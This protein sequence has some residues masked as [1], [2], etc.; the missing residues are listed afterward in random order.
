[1]SHMRCHICGD[2]SEAFA[3]TLVLS[4]HQVSYFR[5]KGCRFIQTEP[6]YWLE[7]AYSEAISELDVGVMQRNLH[8][9]GVT[10]AVIS[11]LFPSGVR[12]LDYAAGYGTLVRL[13]RD[14]GFDFFW[15][16]RYAKNLYA[17]GFEHV[18]GSRYDLLTA[19]EVL[20]HLPHPL[21][22]IARMFELAENILVSTILVPEPAPTPP[23]WWYYAVKSGQHISLYTADSL[24]K[25][26]SRFHVHLLSRGPYHLLTH[27][28]QSS[29]RFRVATS[30]R[31][32]PVVNF[33]CRRPSL[34]GADLE[35]VSA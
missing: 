26:A 13:M 11:L 12:F 33:L 30:G 4:K 32:A 31:L 1:M 20:E 35:R 21:E 3:S 15:S 17:R 24:Q 22:D 34:T 14:R 8:N 7:E 10:A 27:N 5:C 18:P 23:H 16:D 28:Q 29:R 6:P 2:A 9:T 19:F 25:I